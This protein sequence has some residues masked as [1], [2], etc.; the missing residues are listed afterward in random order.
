MLLSDL[1]LDDNVSLM[2]RTIP[3]SLVCVY[4]VC[5]YAGV[6]IV[7]IIFPFHPA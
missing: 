2:L 6:L 3:R 5:V 4:V 1:K 7:A